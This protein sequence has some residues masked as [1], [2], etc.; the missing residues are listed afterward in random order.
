MQR[1]G[2]PQLHAN[3]RE[4]SW[5]TFGLTWPNV[6]LFVALDVCHRLAVSNRMESRIAVGGQQ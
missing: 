6:P 2:K 4:A 3:C 1:I 5:K